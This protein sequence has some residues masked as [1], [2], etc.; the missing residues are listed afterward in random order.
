VGSGV[1]DPAAWGA[2]GRALQ[3]AARAIGDRLRWVDLGGGLG[4]PER[5][6]QP[7]LD[8]LAV[9]ENLRSVKHALGRVELRLEPGRYV[10]S[11]AGVLLAPVTQVRRKGEVMFVGV[12]TGMNSLI[13]PALYGAWHRIVNLTRLDERPDARVH[14]VGPI[15]ESG[16]I[17]GRD[18]WL[19][20][21]HPG[22]VLLI[23]SA[24]AYGASMSSRYNLR[25]PA[26]EVV[27][28]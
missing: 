13:R 15:C 14:V 17:L 18:R 23:A 25:E 5:P 2:V 8:L 22:D 26:E 21:P 20:L 3:E 24:G 10:V 19:P 27:L 1:L 4:V 7:E 28:S 16:D 6:G 12:A 11:E 9:E